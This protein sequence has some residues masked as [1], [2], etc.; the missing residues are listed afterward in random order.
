MPQ[1]SEMN[2]CVMCTLGR[3]QSCE[4][5]IQNVIGIFFMRANECE[6]SVIRAIC[7]GDCYY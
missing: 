4:A 6:N 2:D 1:C 5:V 3:V 7:N